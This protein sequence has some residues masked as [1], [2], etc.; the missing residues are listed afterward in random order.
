MLEYRFSLTCIL[1]T[2]Q[3]TGVDCLFFGARMEKVDIN[4]NLH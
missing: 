2:A 3:R 4:F 1:K